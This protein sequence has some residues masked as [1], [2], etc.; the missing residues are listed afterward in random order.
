MARPAAMGA[1][2]LTPEH[3]VVSISIHVRQRV[4]VAAAAPIA[5]LLAF[6]ATLC[7]V[8]ASPAIASPFLKCVPGFSTHGNAVPS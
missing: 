3:E 2:P 4:P 6:R 1:P 7:K 8:V 5:S